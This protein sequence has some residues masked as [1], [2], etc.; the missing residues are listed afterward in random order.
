MVVVLLSM[1]L[2]FC[3]HVYGFTHRELL[4]RFSEVDRYDTLDKRG[5]NINALKHVLKVP[6]ESAVDMTKSRLSGDTILK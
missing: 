6:V 2:S 5:Q 4:F 3:W 1:N